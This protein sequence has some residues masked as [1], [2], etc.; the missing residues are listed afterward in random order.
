MN[1]TTRED[2]DAP[3]AKVYEAVTDFE[4]FERRLM[5]RGNPN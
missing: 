5:R 3:I 1:L 4:R 2:I